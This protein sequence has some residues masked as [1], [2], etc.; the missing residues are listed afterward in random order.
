MDD[1]LYTYV[2]T[3]I[4]SK[5]CKQVIILI[6]DINKFQYSKQVLAFVNW[7]HLQN[8]NNS[9][10]KKIAQIFWIETHF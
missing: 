9:Q 3:Y 6:Y 7:K 5:R 8:F 10:F 2:C 1:K 4:I